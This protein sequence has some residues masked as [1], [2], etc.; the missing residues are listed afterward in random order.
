MRPVSGTPVVEWDTGTEAE[1]AVL[2]RG[3]TPPSHS[4]LH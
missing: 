2:A 1:L 4:S 3:E